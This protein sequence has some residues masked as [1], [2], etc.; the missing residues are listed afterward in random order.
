MSLAIPAQP[1]NLN[2]IDQD[3]KIRTHGT[4]SKDSELAGMSLT[5]QFDYLSL[6]LPPPHEE[7]A[8]E[9]EEEEEE[10]ED[11]DEEFEEDEEEEEEEEEEDEDEEFDICDVCVKTKEHWTF[12][13]PYLDRIP[14]PER[15]TVGSGYAIV[16]RG[17]HVLGGHSDRAWVGRAIMKSCGICAEPASHWNSEC[18]KNP[19]P[20]EYDDSNDFKVLMEE[21]YSVA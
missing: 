13:C 4:G 3:D 19:D 7:S 21:I 10:E 8:K 2:P 14:N 9:E 15:T 16:C 12:D 17:C 20:G 18:P 5:Q 11:E 1:P 6:A